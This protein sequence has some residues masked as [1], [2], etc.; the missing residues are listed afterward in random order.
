MSES[1]FKKNREILLAPYGGAR[2]LRHFT[3]SLWDGSTYKIGLSRLGFLD[4]QHTAIM[5]ELFA[6]YCKHGE[7]DNDFMRVALECADAFER[8]KEKI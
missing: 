5:H 4:D 1:P 3:L 7:R 2:F 8:N 6:H